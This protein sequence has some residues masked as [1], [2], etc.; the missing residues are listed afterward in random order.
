M[1]TT[2][3]MD[4]L[5]RSELWSQELKQVLT[6]DLMATK[7]V[8]WLSDFPDG[9][10]F[11]IPSISGTA[12]LQD[13]TEDQ[14]ITYNAMDTG[15]FQMTITEYIGAGTYITNKA[16][17]DAFYSAQLISSFV[18][19]Q[20]RA[21]EEKV[22]T[23]VWAL[24][25]Q[26]TASDPNTINGTAHRFV[27]TGTSSIIT[28]ADFARALYSLKKAKVPQNNLVAIVDPSVEYTIN[29]LTNLSN[30]SNNPMWE[31]IVNTGIS[32]GMRFV[33]NIYGFDV[34]TSNYL[35]SSL[36]ETVSG[37]SVTSTGVANLFFSADA[38][39]LPFI[40]AWRQMPVVDSKYNMDL[41]RDEY[42]T[43]CR[44]GLKLYRRE[45]LVVCLTKGDV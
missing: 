3:T 34:Y 17:Q 4:H 11:T 39:I 45:N 18:P 15:E 44:Y 20:R 36:T 2:N 26:Q 29:T 43:T 33:K 30:I 37:V 16:K 38:S 10:T 19:S 22:E 6:D 5:I 21:I 41:Q 27:G 12:E 32:T 25:S 14:P 7:Y 40:G 9:T 35:P 1:N 8:K 42:V 24:Q 28:V 31:G 13:V 23:D